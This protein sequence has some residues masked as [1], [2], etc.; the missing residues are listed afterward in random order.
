VLVLD[1]VDPDVRRE[2]LREMRQRELPVLSGPSD[3]S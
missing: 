3:R 2:A 1:R